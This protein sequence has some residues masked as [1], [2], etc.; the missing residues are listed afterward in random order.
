VWWCFNT[1][2]WSYYSVI[3]S[4]MYPVSVTMQSTT[5]HT[6]AQC[7]LRPALLDTYQVSEKLTC[8]RWPQPAQFN[9]QKSLSFFHFFRWWH[10][11]PGTQKVSQRSLSR[12]SCYNALTLNIPSLPHQRFLPSWG[13]RKTPCFFNSQL[14]DEVDYSNYIFLCFWNYNFQIY[15]VQNLEITRITTFHICNVVYQ[16]GSRRDP[17]WFFNFLRF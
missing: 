15:N 14:Y 2:F 5:L 1:W 10:Q 17:L 6:P 7:F 4:S 13:P 11:T 8:F 3:L 16:A 12:Y 9:L